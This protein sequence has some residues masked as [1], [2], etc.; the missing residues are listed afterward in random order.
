M[1]NCT[2]HFIA[3]G[4]NCLIQGV[5]RIQ[6]LERHLYNLY[7]NDSTYAVFFWG[8]GRGVVGVNEEL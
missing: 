3:C 4:W 1:Q 8:G 7:L 5:L 2:V 6:Y